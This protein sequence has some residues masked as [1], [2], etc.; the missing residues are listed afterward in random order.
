MSKENVEWKLVWGTENGS[1]YENI[2]KLETKE[3]TI[4]K[5]SKQEGYDLHN[6]PKKHTVS[7]FV[8]QHPKTRD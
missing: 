2:K 6:G 1:F 5:H 7:I 3:E 8:V 4:Y